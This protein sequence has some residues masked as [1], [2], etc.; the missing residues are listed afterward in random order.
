MGINETEV[1]TIPHKFTPRPY[2][3]ELLQALDSGYTRAI[4]VWSRRAGKDKTLINL[5]VKKA[6]ERVGIYYYFFP[7]FTQGRRVIWD[8]IDN[9][10]MAFM[11]HIPDALIKS[12]NSNEMKV[13]LNNGSIIQIV[14]TDDYDRV[15]GS[16]PVGCVF[17]EYAWQN[18][19]AYDT[20]RPILR[21]NGGWAV[22]NSTPFGENHF[23][24]LWI[25]A[26]ENDDWFT[27]LVTV[28]T[29]LK[30]D[31][32]KYITTEDIA[33][34]KRS[35][36][37][38]EMVQQEFFCSFQA[39]TGG[40]YYRKHLNLAQEEDRITSVP[41][42]ENALVHTYWDL[43]IGDETSIWFVQTIGKEIHIIDY[44][45][46]SGESLAHYAKVLKERPYVYER[47]HLPHDANARELGTGKSRYEM[48]EG[49]L[50]PNLDTIPRLSVEDG[51]QAAR[52]VFRQ[53]WFDLEKTKTGR[54]ALV[55]YR[56][57]WDTNKKMFKTAPTHDWSSH[58]ADAF[59]YFA[60][61]YTKPKS[62][63]SRKDV[64]LRKLKKFKQ[65][66]WLA[67]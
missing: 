42:D 10:G 59:R 66:S 11:D 7:T 45:S 60:V 55:N 28:D 26:Q 17:S 5:I 49:L 21:A 36:M 12:K 54:K 40:F 64:Y 35:G 63:R 9:G 24:D 29:A 18:P 1:I 19:M 61:G 58:A 43:G 20:V 62:S 33:D 31:G 27:Q 44:Y 47:H 15:R 53:C 22:F 52:T 2:Q 48:L 3:L 57:D 8:G 32:S 13:V 41:Y 65:K 39:N 37:T 34:E 56:R 4:A 6:L 23:Y 46:N 38:D 67:G 51:I 16:N 25:D 30:N 50:G 14:G